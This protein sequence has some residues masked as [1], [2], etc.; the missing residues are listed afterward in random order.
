MY[1]YMGA[2][3]LRAYF[4]GY[5][6]SITKLL[7]KTLNTIRILF[8]CSSMTKIILYK[9]ARAAGT[10]WRGFYSGTVK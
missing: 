3:F 2:Y 6:M 4:N 9:N 7:F 1:V 5:Y 8:M 10:V